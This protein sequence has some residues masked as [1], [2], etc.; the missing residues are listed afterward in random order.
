MAWKSNPFAGTWRIAEMQQW[1]ADII[2]EFV[3]A[4]ISFEQGGTGRMQFIACEL[5]LDGKLTEREGPPVMEFSFVGDDD[6]TDVSGRGWV[7]LDGPD[8]LQGWF[9]FHRGDDSTFV[10]ERRR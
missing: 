4:Q 7:K 3:P 2:H 6:G 9:A 1:D 10:A 8:R 5:D